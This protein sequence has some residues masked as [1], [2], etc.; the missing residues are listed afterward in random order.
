MENTLGDE[1]KRIGLP[2]VPDSGYLA[3]HFGVGR[4]TFNA[5][6]GVHQPGA[7]KKKSQFVHFLKTF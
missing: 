1:C 5:L 2:F 3:P 4:A 7:E 6:M